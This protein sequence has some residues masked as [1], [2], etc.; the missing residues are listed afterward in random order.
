MNVLSSSLS[1]A[2]SWKN[3]YSVTDFICTES[4]RAQTDLFF[5]QIQ[6]ITQPTVIECATQFLLCNVLHCTN[7]KLILLTLGNN[8]L[9]RYK[10]FRHT[11][12]VMRR[13]PEALHLSL[14]KSNNRHALLVDCGI[15]SVVEPIL[16]LWKVCPG[17]SSL[18]C[19]QC[20]LICCRAL[21][22][23]YVGNQEKLPGTS[24]NAVSALRYVQKNA[25]Q[26]YKQLFSLIVSRVQT[27]L[28]L[29]FII[30]NP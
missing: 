11:V 4:Q 28:F 13:W 5:S 10:W 7:M 19:W 26:Y 20:C 24:E 6:P 18:M 14:L 9:L 21:L 29:F 22:E 23:C 27:Q 25:P 17:I 15:E 12:V 8:I 3:P 30:F 16:F 1:N 2:N